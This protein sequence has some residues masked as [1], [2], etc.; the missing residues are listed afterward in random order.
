MEALLTK[1][2]HLAT[3]KTE[4]TSDHIPIAFAVDT[5]VRNFKPTAI[6]DKSPDHLVSQLMEYLV[7]ISLASRTAMLEQYAPY[8]QALRDL[9]PDTEENRSQILLRKRID[10]IMTKLDTYCSQLVVGG[11]NIST[12]DTNLVFK[13][14]VQ[15]MFRLA[16]HNPH[17]KIL[18]ILKRNS[19]YTLIQTPT[20]RMLDFKSFVSPG[21]S[22]GSFLRCYDI[23]VRKFYFPYEK[24]QT[25]DVLD[26]SDPP[27]YCD[28]FSS[29]NNVNVLE[30]DRITY[31]KL[32]SGGKS[33]QEA[34]KSMKLKSVPLNGSQNY[35]LVLNTW[36]DEGFETIADLLQYYVLRD[37]TPL[38]KACEIMSEGYFDLSID[39]WKRCISLPGASQL[40]V[41]RFVPRD[42]YKIYTLVYHKN[43]MRV[44]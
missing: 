33:K 20:L 39:I 32:I 37:V 21:T 7:E 23:D 12:Y 5:N 43:K 17:F 13:Y 16:K 9:R 34:L 24:L 11:W 40:L 2:C 6:I 19:A 8:F 15:V 1:S 3:E 29:L 25:V 38:L 35:Q 4:Y 26:E 41:Y 31:D 42:I 44:Y 10:E 36:R 27:K 28:F 30:A 18:S 22:L 14:F